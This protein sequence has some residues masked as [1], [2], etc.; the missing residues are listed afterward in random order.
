VGLGELVRR[1]ADAAG[2]HEQGGRNALRAVGW[3]TVDLD[4]SATEVP[5]VRFGEPGEEPMLGARALRTKLGSI[6]LLLLEP[7]TEGRL[8]GWLARNGEGVAAFYLE[9]VKASDVPARATVLG[10]PGRL[11]VGQDPADPFLIVLEPV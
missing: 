3:G 6:D 4:R 7:S 10:R 2:P 5:E 11:E 1:L 8:A 9:G